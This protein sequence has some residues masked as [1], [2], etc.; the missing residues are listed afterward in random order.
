M[1]LSLRTNCMSIAVVD[2]SKN[3][4]TSFGISGSIA[5][6][7]TRRGIDDFRMYLCHRYS[8]CILLRAADK[9]L[10]FPFFSSS[11]SQG[12]S[13]CRHSVWRSRCPADNIMMEV[14]H[15]L[16]PDR[17]RAAHAGHVPHGFAGEIAHPDAD[18][19]ACP[20]IPR[21]SCPACPCSFRSLRRSRTGWQS[22]LSRLNVALR[23]SR[24]ERM[25]GDN[26][27]RFPGKHPSCGARP[28]SPGDIR[29]LAPAAVVREGPVGVDQFPERDIRRAE[30]KGRAV[31]LRVIKTVNP[32]SPELC[33]KCT[34]PRRGSAFVPR[35]Y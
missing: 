20:N 3:F 2:V 17:R 15:D 25:F 16:E 9:P 26:E 31:V 21:T 27:G 1:V 28:V 33:S 19:V 24:S 4:W 29:Q 7:D 18:G 12:D 35:G 22:G 34:R 5:I 11:I 14:I 30:C 23:A 10:S 32:N 13:T 6:T 8:D